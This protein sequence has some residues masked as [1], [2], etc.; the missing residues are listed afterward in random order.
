M[1]TA[2]HTPPPPGPDCC[3]CS[4]HHRQRGVRLV[5]LNST[6]GRPCVEFSNTAQNEAKPLSPHTTIQLVSTA[7]HTPPPPGPDCRTCLPQH[8][9]RGVRLVRLNSTNGRRCVEFSNTAQNK[10]TPPRTHTTIKW[11]YTASHTHPPPCLARCT[12]SPHH[13]QRGVHLVCLNS[14]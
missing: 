5:R 6:N 11:A 10:V 3:T 4:P 1:S 7:A 9:Q 2:A 14:T 13:W 12:C 8:R